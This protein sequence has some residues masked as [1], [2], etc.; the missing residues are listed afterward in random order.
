MEIL[1][2]LFTGISVGA[3]VFA[4]FGK[5]DGKKKATS[6]SKEGEVEANITDADSTLKKTLTKAPSIANMVNNQLGLNK[7]GDKHPY[8][9]FRNFMDKM[10]MRAGYP[11]NLNSDDLINACFYCCLLFVFL[12]VS[13]ASSVKANVLLYLYVS[14][15][16]GL[17]LP[18]LLLN[19]AATKRQTAIKKELPYMIDLLTLCIEAGMDFTTAMIRVSPV[20]VNTPLGD[21]IGLLVTELKLGKTRVEGLHDLSHRVGIMELSLIV[22]AIVQADKLGTSLAPTLRIQAED[23]RKHRSL[24]AEEM[25]MKAPVKMLVPIIIFIFPTTFIVLFAP[26]VLKLI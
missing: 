10:L 26:M 15:I 4:L 21:E 6:Q 13:Y 17:L 11:N 20:F 22:N 19:I 2:Y 1:I 23:I 24:M 16:A 9:K 14:F 8:K 7:M 5:G 3:L 12:A 25:A 18:L